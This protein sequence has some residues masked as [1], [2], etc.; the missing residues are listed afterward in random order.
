MIMM[1]I[2]VRLLLKGDLLTAGLP[3]C[4][5]LLP[6][7]LVIEKAFLHKLGVGQV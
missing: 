2:E 7:S 5:A 6:D 3:I 4:E 1:I